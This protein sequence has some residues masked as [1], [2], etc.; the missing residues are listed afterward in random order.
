MACCCNA[1]T[2]NCPCDYVG[3][4]AQLDVSLIFEPGQFLPPMAGCAPPQVGE[5]RTTN[6]NR[7]TIEQSLLAY[8]VYTLRGGTWGWEWTYDCDQLWANVFV[9]CDVEG[10]Y[11][12]TYLYACTD[13]PIGGRFCSGGGD[14]G[15]L[16]TIRPRGCGG[17]DWGTNVPPLPS[18]YHVLKS[19]DPC[20]QS[21]SVNYPL[22]CKSGSRSW[23]W[24]YDWYYFVNPTQQNSA[25]AG[26]YAWT[27]L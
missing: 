14:Y 11:M 20:T 4:L 5:T 16:Y 2:P 21:T 23:N 6:I 27:I 26:T 3:K 7:Y 25:S 18:N 8:P 10:L 17:Y 22:C 19:E 9:P 12:Q 1:S 15:N 24:I 13:E